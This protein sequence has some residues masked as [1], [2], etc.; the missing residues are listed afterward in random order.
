MKL[1]QALIDLGV[2]PAAIHQIRYAP[3]PQ[4][5]ELLKRLKEQAKKAFRRL[6]LELHPDRTG[7]DTEKAA[8]FAFLTTVI[9][10]VEAMEV[11]PPPPQPQVVIEQIQFAPAQ[12]T[13]SGPWVRVGRRVGAVRATTQ[14]TPQGNGL[15]V[16]FM[17]PTR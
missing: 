5:Q 10:Q 17:R 15:H 3:F 11:P 16:V 8:R 9:K 1:A 4:A 7:G 14:Q 2:T 6:A 12:T 13:A